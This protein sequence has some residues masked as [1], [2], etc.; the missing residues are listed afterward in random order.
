MAMRMKKRMQEKEEETRKG[1]FGGRKRKAKAN[2]GEGMEGGQGRVD[3][4]ERRERRERWVDAA[5]YLYRYSRK[6]TCAA[7]LWIDCLTKTKTK[8][9][10]VKVGQLSDADLGRDLVGPQEKAGQGC[11][12]SQGL[13]EKNLG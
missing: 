7:L 8:T 9:K 6:G 1:R 2:E 4:I 3:S 11:Q 5:E 12:G 10:P 13:G